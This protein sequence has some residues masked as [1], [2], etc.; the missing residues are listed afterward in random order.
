[1]KEK[2]SITL[3][4]AELSSVD[5]ARLHNEARAQGEASDLELLDAAADELNADVEDILQYQAD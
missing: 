2:T 5:R 4:K 1:M 3:P